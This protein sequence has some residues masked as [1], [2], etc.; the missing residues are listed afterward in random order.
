MYWNIALIEDRW[1]WNLESEM[2][3][4]LLNFKTF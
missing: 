3:D 1:T 2:L 4:I